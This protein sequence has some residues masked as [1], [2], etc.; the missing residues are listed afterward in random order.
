MSLPSMARFKDAYGKVVA[1]GF[2]NC[3]WSLCHESVIRAIPSTYAD[4]IESSKVKSGIN[5]ELEKGHQ[6]HILDWI[7]KFEKHYDGIELFPE[8]WESDWQSVEAYNIEILRSDLIRL[9]TKELALEQLVEKLEYE[10]KMK[11]HK[12]KK[13]ESKT[14]R[15]KHG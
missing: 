3:G 8:N 10:Q 7:N 11:E 5:T 15:K 2:I 14:K 4:A 1:T 6:K 13:A 9:G 12:T